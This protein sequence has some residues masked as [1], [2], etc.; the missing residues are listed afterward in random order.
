MTSFQF[1]IQKL[2]AINKSKLVI[3]Y[4]LNRPILILRY[5]ASKYALLL[6]EFF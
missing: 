4:F 6:T 2:H 5:S 3:E 1:E